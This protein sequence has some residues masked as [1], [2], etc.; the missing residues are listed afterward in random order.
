MSSD[1]TLLQYGVQGKIETAYGDG[2]APASTE[3]I[4]SLEPPEID[5]SYANDGN[6]GRA[7]EG[8]N[9]LRVA[10]SGLTG[11]LELQT[12]AYPGGVAYSASVYPSIH[13]LLR[14]CGF[15]ATVDVTGAAES[16]TYSPISSISNLESGS[17]VIFNRG[18]KALLKGVYGNVQMSFDG[19]EIPI[20]TF[21]LKG[22]ETAGVEWVAGDPTPFGSGTLI[23]YRNFSVGPPKAVNVN[24]ALGA[25]TGAVLRSCEFNLG[26]DV[27]SRVDDNASG[28]HAGFTP[29]NRDPRLTVLIEA[30]TLG[31]IGAAVIDPYAL[32]AAGT[33]LDVGLTIGYGTQ[34]ERF[35][36]NLDQMTIDDVNDVDDGPTAM[37]ELELVAGVSTPAAEDD[38]EIVFD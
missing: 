4:L 2:A 11:Q 21:D 26:R 5:H 16:W 7:P 34:Y 35:T 1:K 13:D 9:L 14:M 10:K 25:F 17:L 6:R 8:G 3:G 15:D 27:S 12:H 29:G 19:P 33:A 22:L 28:A 30:T 18:Q 36:I 38:V 24:L 37:W 23:T 31:T 32:A 20:W